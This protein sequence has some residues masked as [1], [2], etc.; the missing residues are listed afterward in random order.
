MI[1]DASSSDIGD[2][3]ALMQSV[4]GF[5]DR[6]W[7]P[8]VLERVIGS[9]DAI[10]LVHHDGAGID[11][12]ICAHDLGFRAYL[13][14]LVVAPRVQRRGI[15]KLLLAEVERRV[16][17]RGCDVIVADVWRDAETFYGS[18]GWT[19]PTVMLVRKRLPGIGVDRGVD[20]RAGG[21]RS[22][23]SQLEGGCYCGRVRYRAR[24]VFDAGYCHCSVCRRIH[25]APVV[26]W[27]AVPERDFVLRQGTPRAFHSSTE[28]TR[29]ACAECG[30]HLYYT[31]TRE[32]PPGAGSRLVSVYLTTLDEPGIVRPRIHQWWNDHLPWFETRDDLPR[33][34][35]GRL[36]HPAVRGGAE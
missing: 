25:G 14:E 8:D 10:A 32:P 29:Y 17:E 21:E 30:T 24:S 23:T 35:G 20:G 27:I 1:R 34:A 15:G 13:S 12:F 2:I 7:R 36:P 16:A 22:V 18:Q 26:A 9:H 28:G 33:V 31:D 6:S 19:P 3:R 5:W 11:G 4:D